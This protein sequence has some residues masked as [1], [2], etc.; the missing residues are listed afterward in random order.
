MHLSL[1]LSQSIN[2]FPPFFL[3]PRYRQGVT[4]EQLIAKCDWLRRE[5][6]ARGGEVAMAE[7][8]DR[9]ALV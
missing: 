3:F 5:T 2:I 8:F 4:R 7:G 9:A 6:I 1:S